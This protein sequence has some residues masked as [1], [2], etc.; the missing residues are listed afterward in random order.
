MSSTSRRAHLG[1]LLEKQNR[2]YLL[3]LILH[4]SD[5]ARVRNTYGENIAISEGD[6]RL[7]LALNDQYRDMSEFYINLLKVDFRQNLT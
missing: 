3:G 2:E 6:I 7:R 1:S 4:Q 5:I